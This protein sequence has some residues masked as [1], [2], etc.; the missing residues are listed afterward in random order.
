MTPKITGAEY[1]ARTLD[2]YGVSAVFLSRRS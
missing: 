1:L 2:A